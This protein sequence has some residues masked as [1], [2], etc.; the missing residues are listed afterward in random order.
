MDAEV[1]AMIPPTL[2]GMMDFPFGNKGELDL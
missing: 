1:D 2:S